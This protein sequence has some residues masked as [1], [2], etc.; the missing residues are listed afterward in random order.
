[1]TT[2]GCQK[3][4]NVTPRHSVYDDCQVLH[5]PILHNYVDSQS[6]ANH[7]CT[8][9]LLLASDNKVKN[10]C[11]SVVHI[12][13]DPF[14][15]STRQMP[16]VLLGTRGPLPQLCSVS[17]GNLKQSG[18]SMK[19]ESLFVQRKSRVISNLKIIAKVLAHKLK[20]ILPSTVTKKKRD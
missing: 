2:L 6:S 18:L 12:S 19:M 10:L 20:N 5:S 8:L 17:C 4:L 1:M 16:S 15:R 11:L 9:H 14:I 7:L 3:Q 13:R